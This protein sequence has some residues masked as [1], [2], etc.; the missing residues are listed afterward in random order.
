MK[1]LL[2]IVFI[3]GFIG[4]IF[5]QST[6]P[7][8]G[9]KKSDDNTG[10]VL[11]YALISPTYAASVTIKPNAYETIVNMDTLTGSLT[12][13][14]TITNC[15]LADKL[16]VILFADA[17][18]RAVTFSTGFASGSTVIVPGGTTITLNF[19][20]NGTTGWVVDGAKP[21][22]YRSVVGTAYTATATVTASELA[23]GLLTVTSGTATLTL[24]T[25]T[26]LA[27]QLG[28]TAGSVFDF[29][30]LN[31]LAGGTV[32]IAVGSGITAVSA[33]TGGTTLTL[34]NSATAGAAGFRITFISTTVATISRIY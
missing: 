20:F 25:A 22:G 5:A 19:V 31:V 18:N 10:R 34:A 16:S 13:I 8:F 7:R 27:T 17:S 29:Q 3:L 33:V 30:V 4:S 28:A 11:T 23:G 12:L 2:S 21:A 32:T 24:P 1:K 9:T 14:S 6:T 15:K 26:L